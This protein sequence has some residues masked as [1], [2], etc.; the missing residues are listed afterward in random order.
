M[1]KSNFTKNR[2][3]FRSE[4]L[5]QRNAVATLLVFLFCLLPLSIHAQSPP[6]VW[7][8]PIAGPN[9]YANGSG[10]A[11]DRQ[12]NIYYVS[13]FVSQTFAVGNQTLTNR[14]GLWNG[15]ISKFSKTGD[16]FWVR[17]IGGNYSDWPAACATDANGNVFVTGVF[18]STNLVLGDTVLT[19]SLTGTQSCFLAE[20]DPQGNVL[21]ARQ[22]FTTVVP[23]EG[24]TWDRGTSVA[25]DDDG[26]AWLA[27]NYNSSNVVFGTNVL[28]N[29]TYTDPNLTSQ[30]FLVKYSNAGDVLWAKTIRIDGNIN[31]YS[32]I[33]LD[34]NS[35]ALLCAS[36]PGNAVVGNITITNVSAGYQSL[37]LAKFDPDGNALW[38]E[39]AMQPVN[40]AYIFPGPMAVDLQGNGWI[41]GRY[42]DG[43]A[44]FP[45]NTLPAPATNPQNNG[46]VAKF[47]SS[48]N[49]LWAGVPTNQSFASV[50]VDAIG[51]VYTFDQ[52]GISK[53]AAGGALLWS[54]NSLGMSGFVLGAVDPAGTLFLVG[55]YGVLAGSLATELSGPTLN[56][57]PSGNEV[58]VSWPMNEAGLGLESAPGLS[59]PW[60]P[61][62]NP[63]PAT[64][65]NQYVVTNAVPIG[66]QYFRLG[67]F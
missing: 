65:G 25:I 67:N 1:R 43:A 2:G 66:S 4:G 34:T 44:A 7:S 36:F 46:F 20:Y 14:G 50:S 37:L 12:D 60:S 6:V 63:A 22:T 17:Q 10:V 13:S 45:S 28:V 49:F 11:L 26:D 55:G 38:A 47:D 39:L 9:A 18:S 16:F 62:T 57:Q 58:V 30:D 51:N 23:E 19:N 42:F 24:G 59:G 27:G 48:G 41:S 8:E 54:T 21:W 33:G 40:G 35:N 15:F 52:F 61:V 3:P 5:P 29:P 53:Y 56:I 32:S 31:N 64:V